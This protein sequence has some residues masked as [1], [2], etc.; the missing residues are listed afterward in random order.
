MFVR[1]LGVLVMCG[2]VACDANETPKA[3]TPTSLPK[4]D[5]F[6]TTRPD[7][8]VGLAKVKMAA[9]AGDTVTFLARVGGKRTVFVDGSAIFLAAD[10]ELTS[11]ELMGDE[12]HCT[13]PW[14]YCCEDADAMTA[15]LATVRL[16]DDAGKV[17]KESADGK[18][19]LEALKFVVVTGVVRE[20]ND[21]GVFVVDA[22]EIWVGGKPSRGDELGGA[23]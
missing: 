4:A 9:K 6:T 12:D 2:V 22:S 20:R 18:G 21:E 17:L 16:V 19:G 14:D 13:M 8:A 11:C 1:V 23:Y 5:V 7:D 10:P 15:G 3:V